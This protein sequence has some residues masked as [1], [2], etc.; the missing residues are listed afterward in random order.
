MVPRLE[1]ESIPRIKTP[2]PLIKSFLHAAN[3]NLTMRFAELTATLLL[4]FIFL[5]APRVCAKL[6]ID[7]PHNEIYLDQAL[8]GTNPAPPCKECHLI[9]S[10]NIEYISDSIG[11]QTPSGLTD[12]YSNQLC[13]SCHTGIRA[14]NM[15]THSSEAIDDQ[16]GNWTV[17]C[18]TCHWP[19]EQIQF[20]TFGDQTF[21]ASGIIEN[22]TSSTLT[23]GSKN[24]LPDEFKGM[25]LIPNLDEDYSNYKIESNTD[26][27]I[28]V[29][30]APG[31]TGEIDLDK[32]A[33]GNSYAVISGQL[34][35]I[36][37]N[38]GEI[39]SSPSKSG[40]KRVQFLK[41]EPGFYTVDVDRDNDGLTDDYAGICEVCHTKTA[42][43]RNNDDPLDPTDPWYG[44]PQKPNRTHNKTE[45]CTRCHKHNLG[46]MAMGG[47]AHFVHVEEENGPQIS[48][49]RGD[50]GCHGTVFQTNALG[51]ILFNDGLTFGNTHVCDDCHSG[52]GAALAMTVGEDNNGDGKPDRIY[53]DNPGVWDVNEKCG[54]CHDN[55][56]GETFPAKIPNGPSIKLDGFSNASPP[57]VLGDD[58]ATDPN[59]SPTFGFFTTGHGASS[60]PLAKMSWQDDAA[61]GNPAPNIQCDACHDTDSRH[62]GSNDKRL[63]KGWENDSSN[64]NCFQCHDE[65]G[66]ADPSDKATSAP[67]FYTNF[68]D[69]NASAHGQSLGNLKCTDCHDVH[70]LSGTSPAMT[71]GS[72]EGLC[73]QC[74]TDGKILNGSIAGYKG[75]H[76]GGD[77]QSIL[78]NS[79]AIFPGAI[80][81]G[82][83]KGWAIYNLTDGSKGTV[84]TYDFA[85][86]GDT[87][88]PAPLSGG[89]D[90]N[91]DNG[92]EYF[93]AWADDIQQAFGA[94][95]KHD[96]GTS[97]VHNGKSYTLECV[98]CHNVHTVSGKYWDA[99]KN[100]SPVTRFPPDAPANLT[101]WGDGAGEK[102]D[103]FAASGTY[104]TPKSDL[105]SGSELPDYASF[106]LD[107][108]GQAGSAPFGISWTTDPH[109]KQSANQ[110]NGYGVCPN[111]Y[112]CGK[113]EGW[114][115]DNCVGDDNSGSDESCWPVIPRFLGD[116]IGS[117]KPY[118]HEERIAGANFTLSCTDCHEAHG[119]PSSSMVRAN[120]NNGAGSWI[121]NT[122]CNNCHY[123]YSDWHAGMSCGTASCHTA[124]SIHR[125]G[126]NTGSQGTRTFNKDLVLHYAF[127]NNL[128][129][130]SSTWQLDGGWRVT[131][132]SY[133]AG[134]F[135]KAISINDDPIEVGTENAY[136]S[137]D[138][139]YHGTWVYTE[140]KYNMTLEAWVY[141]D[142]SAF[143][144]SEMRVMAKHT[145][146]NGG[147]TMELIKVGAGWRAA[148]LTNINGGDK[149]WR[150]S[151]CNGLRG[152]FS[153]IPIPENKWTHIAATYDAS[154]PDRDAND[155]SVGRVRIYVNG[156]DVTNSYPNESQCW[157]QPGPG[158][159][160]MFPHS[161]WN[162]IDP[163][164]ICYAGHWCASAFSVAGLNWSAPNDNF[165]GRLD[166]VKVWNVTKDAD[167]FSTDIDPAAGPYI[168]FAE[169]IIG[170]ANLTVTLS[171]G[172]YSDTGAS[173]ALTPG[174]F[175]LN[176]PGGRTVLGV[177]HTPG[178]P[179]ATL[180]LSSIMGSINDFLAASL[181]FAANAAFD[182]NGTAGETA[183][184]T[185]SMRS[186]CPPSPITFELNEAPGS[187][188]SFDDQNTIVG[189]V[190]GAGT[191][192]GNEFSGGG[193]GSG[194]YINFPYNDT[195]IQASTAMTLEA[196]IKPSNIGSANYVTRIL[197]RDGGGN[198]Q[199]SVWKNNDWTTYN[200]P[201]G[202]ASIALWVA[203]LDTH[204][205][206]AWKVAL[207]NYTGGADAGE[208]SCPI[209]S[210]HWY[211]VKT[212][213][214]TARPGGTSG[215]PFS[216]ADIFIDDQGTDGAGT[217][218]NWAGF[219]N[220]T[221]RN[222]SLV[223]PTTQAFYTDDQIRPN[224]GAFTI[225]ANRNNTANNIF[226]GL[227]DWITW[228]ETADYSGVEGAP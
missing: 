24:W 72:K 57:N 55:Q 27:T 98:S 207:T 227:I 157:T 79:S 103:D 121:W 180:T 211:Q 44:D 196:R 3:K 176:D 131:S 199:M 22:V 105:F 88:L 145:Y 192:T 168:A 2:S 220:C 198:F 128:K 151:D 130:S 101:P 158:E 64:S 63:K 206:N 139:G 133:V 116:Q 82:D 132:G 23:D 137:T 201:T 46:F 223:D 205:G 209:V 37:V 119:G 190:A 150:S 124:N 87:S 109:G 40:L 15:E 166:E 215:Q 61:V 115:N 197:A 94:G 161:D 185:L 97:F 12:S 62:F 142:Y 174:D 81:G 160:A 68:S 183:T 159:D 6:Q 200:S 114:D 100:L 178:S 20:R 187:A 148:L 18:D 99:D 118:N 147:Y 184:T 78:I 191:L 53:W 41:N 167:Y 5:T 32:A 28:T 4:T 117:R 126:A 59:D 152:A 65:G 31:I 170:S 194:R 163:A 67:I 165:I 146:W 83:L 71:R 17:N 42:Y 26:T 49:L 127:S 70:G 89:V 38:L 35:G 193:T 96:L 69:Y 202:E 90:N 189:E 149:P 58:D 108:H 143:G 214:N 76:D 19:H 182:E 95:V 73:Y 123:Y 30:T 10:T 179:A 111:W 181:G 102:M 29:Y 221:D 226:D 104:R 219:I 213:W 218:E 173:S 212:V 134:K 186:S 48:C 43:H 138:A 52:T 113:A 204:G 171:E 85:D 208:N 110:P 60:G 225:G 45:R 86:Y 135:G 66:A 141:P 75:R 216:P 34:I 33:A 56:A 153:S 51:E 129:D 228:R 54:T 112:G 210:N 74:H 195:C 107:C 154:G 21:I 93:V 140:M 106:C 120:P 224:D 39:T 172:A 1:K 122:M 77:N 80:S 36:E 217:N 91:W 8:I 25:V 162:D 16:Y 155:G 11:L 7:H 47:G 84:P 50:F 175:I 203:P 14:K 136:W 9:N 164:K 169:G 92:D 144:G 188:Y 13:W 177:A 222:Q 156:E 125:M